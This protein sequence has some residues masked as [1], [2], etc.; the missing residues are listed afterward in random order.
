[1][2]VFITGGTGN[3]GSA[4]VAELLNHDHTVLALAR[5]DRSANA[6]ESAGAEALR[7]SLLDLDALRAGAD[8]ADGIIHLAFSNDFSSAEAVAQSVAEESAAI[9]A[10]G[11]SLVGSG[12]P[13]VV[14]SGTPSIPGRAS[15]ENDSLPTAGPV[16]G[17]G[18][19][20]NATLELAS[21]G[22]RA[23]AVR[24]PRTVHNEGSGGFAGLLAEIAR[25]SRVAGYPGDGT[26]RW[27]AVH[28]LD[29]A[30][31]F[32]LALEQA[33]AGTSWHAVDDEGDAVRDIAEVIGRRLGLP[34]QQVPQEN[35]GPLGAIF[36]A[37]QPSS[38]AHTR[39][40]LGWQP[41]HPRLLADLE[42]IQP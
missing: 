6:V 25:S 34:V 42:N 29:A 24:L 16:A 15:T 1:M 30:A 41:T 18:V 20:V 7:G 35:F 17:R 5:S 22:V 23:T 36:A 38:S 8:Q 4:V 40:A 11:Q 31:L 28:S 13:F 12:R 27:P 37:D 14:C 2:K 32:R 3:I 33:P 19:A 21:Q 39:E 26:Q 9:T 10:L